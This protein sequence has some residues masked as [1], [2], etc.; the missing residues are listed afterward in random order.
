MRRYK[1]ERAREKE[2]GVC[3]HACVWN[4]VGKMKAVEFVGEEV[5]GAG[6]V[7]VVCCKPQVDGEMGI[8]P[9]SL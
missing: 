7:G 6:K 9:R 3:V 8:Q 5:V 2:R 1:E 4:G